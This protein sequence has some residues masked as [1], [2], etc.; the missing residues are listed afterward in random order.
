MKC[1]SYCS[2][3]YNNTN[4]I[5]Y[6]NMESKPTSS[7][8]K[9][10]AAKVLVDIKEQVRMEQ[11]ERAERKVLERAER[12]QIVDD[13]VEQQGHEHFPKDPCGCSNYS[14]LVTPCGFSFDLLTCHSSDVVDLADLWTKEQ[15]T[16]FV[17]KLAS[18]ECC[19]RHQKNRP[20]TL[21]DFQEYPFGSMKQDTECLCHC[22]Q[23]SRG[24]SRAATELADASAHEASNLSGGGYFERAEE[25][26]LR[27]CV[28]VLAGLKA[29]LAQRLAEAEGPAWTALASLEAD[30][31]RGTCV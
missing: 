12:N 23:I 29:D 16:L 18:C 10:E 28:E 7:L 8:S 11:Q 19:E 30:L 2:S 9:I 21:E 26:M 14:K 6:T 4:Q 27:A 15:K 31:A 1:N 5:V 3:I 20:T 17:E 25:A 24:I 13:D 22:R